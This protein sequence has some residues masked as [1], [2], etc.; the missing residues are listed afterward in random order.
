MNIALQLRRGISAEAYKYK[1]TFTFWLLILAPA[2]VPIINFII[3]WQRGPQVVKEGMNAWSTLIGFSIDPANFLFPFFIMMVALLVNNI[4]YSS[5]TWKLI[6]AQPLSRLSLY[7]SKI[8]VFIFMIFISLMLFGSFTILVGLSM[9]LVQPDLGFEESFSFSF[10]YAL[11]I[12]IFLGTLG[13]ASIQFFVSQQSKN[14][15]LPLGIGIAGVISFMIAMQGWEHAPYHPYGYAILATGGVRQEGFE[16][17][18]DMT[19]VYKS[20]VVA[21]IVFTASG[22]IQAKKRI[23]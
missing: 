1:K 13:M 3:L 20:L 4:E 7:L 18:A 9:R 17:W 11:M 21:A 2:F 23:I 12:K 22:I 19:S 14:L 15:I 5:N 8:K 16:V 6:Y 10:Q